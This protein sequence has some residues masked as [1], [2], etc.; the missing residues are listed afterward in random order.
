MYAG[1]KQKHAGFFGKDSRNCFR[2]CLPFSS[3]T[4]TF[5]PIFPQK[6]PFLRIF[7]QEMASLMGKTVPV[8]KKP[9]YGKSVFPDKKFQIKHINNL[10]NR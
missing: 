7:R 5:K 3:K 2:F 1:K 10:N 8:L 9:R 4:T 6:P